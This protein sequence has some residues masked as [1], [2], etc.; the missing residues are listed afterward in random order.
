MTFPLDQDGILQFLNTLKL[1]PELEPTS[2][3]VFIKKKHEDQEFVIFFTIRG[4][5]LQIICYFPY[6]APKEKF[7]DVARLLHIFNR[8]ID[9]PGFCL[10]E[11][12]GLIFYRNVIPSLDGS[13]DEK[14]A[15]S[16]LGAQKNVIETFHK[17]ILGVVTGQLKID[18]IT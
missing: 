8:D 6:A 18:E 16:Y 10:D 9:M 4:A 5:S 7:V 1:S 2:K 13:V 14:L 17:A 11:R 3:Q 15:L 12:E